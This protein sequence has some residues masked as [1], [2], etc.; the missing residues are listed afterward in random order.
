MILSITL[1]SQI[2][3]VLAMSDDTALATYKP[4]Y[5]WW[6]NYL[7]STVDNTTGEN[8]VQCP[9]GTHFH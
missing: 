7:A 8:A 1:P 3:A 9:W 2:P 5:T 6:F 4:F